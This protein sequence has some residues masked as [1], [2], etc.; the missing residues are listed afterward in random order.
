[1]EPPR[2]AGDG[3]SAFIVIRACPSTIAMQHSSTTPLLSIII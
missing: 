3:P 2:N 1:V